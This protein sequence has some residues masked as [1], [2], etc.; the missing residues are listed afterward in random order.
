M[1]DKQDNKKCTQRKL[2]NFSKKH[3]TYIN[4][5]FGDM[6]VREIIAEKFPHKYFEF[7]VAKA[8]EADFDADSDHHFLYNKKKKDYVCSVEDGFQDTSKN[9]NDTLCQSYSLLTYFDMKISKYRKKR[10]MDMIKMYR[11]ILAEP[12]FVMFL[13]KDI[14]RHKKNKKL[15]KN[16]TKKKEENLVMDIQ[17]ILINIKDVLDRWENYGYHYFIGKGKCPSS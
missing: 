12:D 16:F 11:T 6:T 1:P 9:V 10:Q 14:I 4:Q 7:D 3:Y 17:Y 5:I 13:D 8:D 2:N 15:W